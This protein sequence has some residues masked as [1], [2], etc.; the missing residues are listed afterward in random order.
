MKI[1]LKRLTILSYDEWYQNHLNLFL[2]S[3]PDK[4][5]HYQCLLECLTSKISGNQIPISLRKHIIEEI[6]KLELK[7][8]NKPGFL[9][10]IDNALATWGKTA[11]SHQYY[12]VE[13][14]TYD[15]CVL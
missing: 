6:G 8:F 2:F 12:N 3:R 1:K 13:R 9:K 10:A 15:S 14:V 4:R 11:D 7:E 5:S